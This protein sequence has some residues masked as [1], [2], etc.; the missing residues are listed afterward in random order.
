MYTSY[1]IFFFKLY[2]EVLP[3]FNF[4]LWRQKSQLISFVRPVV[5]FL[6]IECM[7]ALFL[8]T[9]ALGMFVFLYVH[10]LHYKQLVNKRL[11]AVLYAR[12]LMT[13]F[14]NKAR[15]GSY[16]EE[17]NGMLAKVI[18]RPDAH[19]SCFRHIELQITWDNVEP[20]RGSSGAL[21]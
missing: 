12:A 17:Y 20:L 7:L 14:I 2:K 21:V 15:V 9:A 13:R 3:I 4:R 16:V 19:Y 5:G 18:V 1:V 11:A 10:A 8:S 6:L